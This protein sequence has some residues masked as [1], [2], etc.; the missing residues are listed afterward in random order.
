MR[1]SLIGI[2]VMF[3]V[4]WGAGPAAQQAPQGGGAPFV[5]SVDYYQDWQLTQ[6]IDT[7]VAPG[8]TLYTKIVFSEPMK[9]K[10][11]DDSSARPVLYCQVG[12]ERIRYR[13]A[14]HGASGADF[15]SGDAKP[16]QGG[17]DDYICKYTIPE[18]ATGEFRTMVGK[19]SADTSGNTMESFYTHSVRLT[20]SNRD[21]TPVIVEGGKTL[22]LSKRIGTPVDSETIIDIWDTTDITASPVDIETI[23]DMLDTTD[24]IAVVDTPPDQEPRGEAFIFRKFLEQLLLDLE[25]VFPSLEYDLETIFQTPGKGFVHPAREPPGYGVRPPYFDMLGIFVPDALMTASLQQ[26]AVFASAYKLTMEE[27]RT[28]LRNLR[29][30]KILVLMV[31]VVDMP[32][33][34][35]REAVIAKINEQTALPSKL[36][37]V[38]EE[39]FIRVGGPKKP[40]EPIYAGEMRLIGSLKAEAAGIEDLTGLEYATNLRGLNLGN[41]Y[42]SDWESVLIVEED[43]PFKYRVTKPETPNRISDLRPLE[44]LKNLITL[45]LECNAVSNLLPLTFLKNLQSLHLGENNITSISPLRNL[46]NLTFLTLGNYSYSP[47]WAGNNTVQDLSPLGDLSKLE[48][49][50]VSHNP[51]GGSIDIVRSLPK[52][53]HLSAGCSGVSNLRP[54]LEHPK[55]GQAGGS[56][57]LVYNPLTEEDIPDL[58]ALITR[59]VDVENGLLWDFL[60]WDGSMFPGGFPGNLEEFEDQWRSPADM[61]STP[62]NRNQVERCSESYRESIRAAPTLQLPIR[63]EPDLLSS[64]WHDLSH[65]PEETALLSN[66]PN[67]FNPETWI[68]YQLATPAE[69]RVTIHAADGRLVRTLVLGYQAAGVY[70]SKGRAAYWDGYNAQGEPVASGVY[71]Y[72]LMT[73]DYTATRKLLIRK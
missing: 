3:A 47:E 46:T 28:L 59:G 1:S 43:Q 35:L 48:T 17:T 22:K 24:S 58:V 32:D 71:F 14:R 61:L 4:F 55:L 10:V 26:V 64:V 72:T 45:D 56:V 54:F 7:T 60:Q 41:K 69:V 62:F 6:P 70:K 50:Y 11:A 67:P 30:A 37:E 31:A 12:E 15:V 8:T 2:A 73:S 40:S 16:L 49:L 13:I 25:S 5:K 57:Y 65:V 39:F 27:A 29:R 9:L 68:P 51:V 33:E 21:V 23:I 44:N 20:I 63:T 36:R 19:L 42:G 52:L 18:G 53:Y 34:N 38:P 66:Y